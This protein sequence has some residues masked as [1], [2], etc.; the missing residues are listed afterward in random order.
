MVGQ[1]DGAVFAARGS[2][3]THPFAKSAKWW[4][5][6]TG[7]CSLRAG[8][9]IPTLSQRARN[10]GAARRGCVRCARVWKYPPFRK[11]RE[12]VGQ[13]DGAVF[14]ARGSGN[15]HPFAKSA[16]WWGSQTGLCSLRAG[17]EIPTLSQ[18]AR[19]GGAARRGC[20]RC[21]RVW[22]YPP[23]RKEREMVGQPDG[24]VF[25]ARVWKY[26]PFRKER[27]MVGQPDGAVFAARVW[28][29]PPF[30]KE[31]EMVGQPDG[32]VFAAR[33]SGNTHP[34]AKNA[35]WWGSRFLFEA[36]KESP[37]SPHTRREFLQTVAG[38]LAATAVGSAA[39]GNP[40]QGS[41]GQAAQSSVIQSQ[42]MPTNSW[43]DFVSE[44][45]LV[46]RFDRRLP[47]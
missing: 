18:R 1:P 16:K 4:G 9:E 26:P 38:T 46:G 3:N 35:K 15:T 19:N 6:Q 44:E 40:A 47:D 2:G 8:L 32:A 39:Q 33:G 37:I 22:K 14:A 27:E 12:M 31:R 42:G 23:F 21:A 11:E 29:Y 45:F 5:S 43:S 17:L 24:A 10:G 41:A 13:P 34:F 28:K 30:R 7:L 25:A 20:V 36:T